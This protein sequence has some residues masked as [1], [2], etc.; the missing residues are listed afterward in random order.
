MR[1]DV[2]TDEL[3]WLLYAQNRIGIFSPVVYEFPTLEC[4]CVKLWMK[5]LSV[6]S[7]HFPT[8]EWK[9]LELSEPTD[10]YVPS[11]QSHAT[12]DKL[13]TAIVS[14]S[15]LLDRVANC[16]TDNEGFHDPLHEDVL[17]VRGTSCPQSAR[18]VSVCGFNH[19]RCWHGSNADVEVTMESAN[20]HMPYEPI[21]FSCNLDRTTRFNVTTP[22][23]STFITSTQSYF[24][25]LRLTTC[26]R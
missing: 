18:Y 24:D 8:Q 10:L 15:N 14:P 19:L 16:D 9:V 23:S 11:T 26:N 7:G 17:V 1:R 25:V 22:C 4:E 20:V 6:C 12:N 5:R 2:R 21:C 13:S 3:T